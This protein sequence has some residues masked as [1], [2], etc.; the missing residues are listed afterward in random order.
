M[1]GAKEERQRI[2]L[3][4]YARIAFRKLYMAS[5][6]R[7]VDISALYTAVPGSS[8]RIPLRVYQTWKEPRLPAVHAMGVRR[9]RK[10]NK[11]CSF[12]FFDDARMA[13]YMR[14]NYAGHPI[15]DVFQR[16][17]I[18]ASK[19]DIWRYCILYREGGIYCDIDS[20]L[21]IPFRVLL[22]DDPSELLSF[23]GNPWGDL[24]QVGDYADP[25]LFLARPPDAVAANLDCP[26]H[27]ILN[28]LLCFE[29]GHPILAE[30]I[31]LIVRHFPFFDDRQFES[32]WQAVVHATG[33]L[34]FTQAIW[35][36][37]EKTGSRP[38]QRGI[39]FDGRGIF[40]LPGS[41]DRYT[42]SPHYMQ[43]KRTS[44]T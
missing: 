4:E 7:L 14:L 40:K 41:G 19:A 12:E 25:A 22:K 31:D 3:D 21:S 44:L 10:L 23:E 29:K 15:L 9:F 5:H 26:D 16:I 24:M 11:D 27:T 32:V 20:A 17:K 43:M 1:D 2:S 33:P 6:P 38:Y 36:W 18:P 39:D 13:E 35:K 42:V 37:M 8:G 28:W 30:I 34:A